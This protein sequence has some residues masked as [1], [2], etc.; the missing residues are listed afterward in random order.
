MLVH[1]SCLAM[2]GDSLVPFSHKKKQHVNQRK[3]HSNSPLAPIG[4]ETLPTHKQN[5]V[6]CEGF[7]EQQGLFTLGEILK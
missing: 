4:P 5:Y 2:G 6:K 3:G 1:D 7:N